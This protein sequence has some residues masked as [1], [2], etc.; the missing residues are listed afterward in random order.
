MAINRMNDV[1][2][3]L[4]VTVVQA[5]ANDYNISIA[6]CILMSIIAGFHINY[7]TIDPVD[8]LL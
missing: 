4:I 3:L 6:K 1:I 2:R 7:K 5:S 8:I